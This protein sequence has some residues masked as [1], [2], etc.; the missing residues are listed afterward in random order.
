M[1]PGHPL[2]TGDA[3]TAE[4]LAEILGFADVNDLVVGIAH[5]VNARLPG[6]LAE[7][8][9]PSRSTSGFGSG[10]SRVC[11]TALYLEHGLV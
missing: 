10:N 9:F 11:G 7:K 8:L 6:N 4:P 3:V 5:F 1:P 2:G